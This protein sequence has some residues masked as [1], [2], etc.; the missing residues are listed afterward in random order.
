MWRLIKTE[1]HYSNKN[2]MLVLALLIPGALLYMN[3][4]PKTGMNSMLF[5]LVTATIFQLLVFRS[6]E[7]RDRKYVLLPLS[8]RQLAAVRLSLFL[9]PCLGFY[10][11]YLIL[12]LIFKDA[13]PRWQHDIYDEMMFFGLILLGFSVYFILHDLYASYSRRAQKTETDLVMMIVLVVAIMLG[14]PLTLASI[15]GDGG[16]I[17]RT[18]CFAMGLAFLYPAIVAFER[19][20]SYLE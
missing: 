8:I 9:I 14:I 12:Q 4:S 19:R 3:A 5:P 16:N 11:V 6:M 20:K 18:L 10:G 2:I 7:K 1:F 13:G 17:L 15:W